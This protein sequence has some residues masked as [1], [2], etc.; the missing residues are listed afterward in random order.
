MRKK[1]LVQWRFVIKKEAPFVGIKAYSHNI[2]ALA[3]SAIASRWGQ[4][5]ANKAIE[6]FD[7][8]GKGWSLI[9]EKRN[10]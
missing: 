7:L 8:K 5:E 10:A 6:D 2:I 3:L 9:K 4:K 1:T